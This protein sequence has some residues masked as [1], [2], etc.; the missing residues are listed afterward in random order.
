[1]SSSKRNRLIKNNNQVKYVGQKIRR[2]LQLFRMM[3][4]LVLDWAFVNQSA[5]ALTCFSRSSDKMDTDSN[6]TSSRDGSGK[7]VVHCNI[8]WHQSKE[9]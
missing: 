3:K 1:M 6:L 8:K 7:E 4:Q 2:D 5:L 9:M